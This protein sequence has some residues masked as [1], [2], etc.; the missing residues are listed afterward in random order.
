MSTVV[1]T[2]PLAPALM[3]PNGGISQTPI[4]STF[5]WVNEP[6]VIHYTFDGSTPTTS[7]PKW[8]AEAPRQPGQRF[9]FNETTTVK[10]FAVDV[11]GNVQNNYKPDG[12]GK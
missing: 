8:N 3:A 5:E 12:N 10:W 9:R 7:S 4:V 6:S 1:T 2:W 11:A